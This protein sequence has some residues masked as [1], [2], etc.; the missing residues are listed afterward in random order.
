MS[1]LNE[2]K[3]SKLAIIHTEGVSMNIFSNFKN[4]KGINLKE[5]L[6]VKEKKDNTRK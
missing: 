3:D 5:L 2:S 6:S 4:K 1:I